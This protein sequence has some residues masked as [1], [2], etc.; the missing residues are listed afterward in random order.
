[1]PGLTTHFESAIIPLSEF[2]ALFMVQPRP[3]CWLQ[4]GRFY[5]ALCSSR[6]EFLNPTLTV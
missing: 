3:A 5:L 4:A 6:K 2:G 1:M